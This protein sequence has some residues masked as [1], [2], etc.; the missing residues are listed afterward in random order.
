[1]GVVQ[2][3]GGQPVAC[4]CGPDGAPGSEPWHNQQGLVRDVTLSPSAVAAR[5]GACHW[6]LA[7]V[8]GEERAS[9]LLWVNA[10][11]SREW[12][13]TEAAALALAA[14]ALARHLCRPEGAPRW[15]HQLQMRRRQQRFDEAAA[16]ARRI[17]HDYGNV[18]TGII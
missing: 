16:A 2:L 14:Q 8:D 9:W 5:E 11:A 6:L 3:P 15:A 18:L 1:A 12:S 10:P 13:P 4:S 17:A 7:A